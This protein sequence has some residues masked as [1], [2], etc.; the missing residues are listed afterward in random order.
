MKNN[1]TVGIAGLGAIGMPVARWLDNGVSGSRLVGVSA[2]KERAKL[3]QRFC[4]PTKVMDLE[5]L[6]VASDV[7]VEAYPQIVLTH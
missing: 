3:S 2:N 1:I 7:L 4:N 5:E 6:I